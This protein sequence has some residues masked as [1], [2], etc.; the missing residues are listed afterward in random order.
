ML[1]V[2]LLLWKYTNTATFTRQQLFSNPWKCELAPE[3]RSK[4]ELVEIGSAVE[5]SKK[6]DMIFVEIFGFLFF[7]FSTSLNI[8]GATSLCSFL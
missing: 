2:I 4:Y 3:T 5:S 8:H 1:I 7:S 6:T